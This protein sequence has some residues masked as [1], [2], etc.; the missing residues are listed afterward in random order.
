MIEALDT[1]TFQNLAIALFIG[2]LVGVERERKHGGDQWRFGGIRTFSLIA[3]GGG[4]A[5]WLGDQTG[6]IW[7]LVVLGVSVGALLVASYT[8]TSE[9][10]GDA[11]TTSEVAAM[12]VYFLGVTSG[13]GYPEVAVPIGIAVAGLLAFEE[14]LHSA[15]ARIG[16]DDL[17]AGLKLLFA[18]FIVLPLLPDRGIDPLGVLNPASLWML[19]I[20]ISGISLVGYVAVRWLGPDRGSAL[21]GLFSGL[22]SSTAATLSFARQSRDE[23]AASNALA[24]GVLLAWTVMFVRVVVEAAVVNPAIVASVA[25]PMVTLAVVG[26]LYALWCYRLAHGA[27]N[28]GKAVPLKNPFSLTAAVQFAALYAAVLLV[29]ALARRYLPDQALYAIAAVAGTTDVDA[30]TLSMAAL[31]RDSED[32][33]VPV[34]AIVIAAISNTCVKMGMIASLG[35]PALRR[36]VGIGTLLLLL[37]ASGSLVA[38]ALLGRGF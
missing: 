33:T 21:T 2:A 8:I 13:W 35:D 19:V 20:L 11:G 7:P 6:S 5:G 25:V 4:L 23:P 9:R 12:V 34:R 28:D 36:R 3:I 38:Q 29:V 26:A 32:P 18:T 24:A 10:T 37:A 30:I 15:V 16:S 1:L 27:T 22:V 17:A 31:A 14:P